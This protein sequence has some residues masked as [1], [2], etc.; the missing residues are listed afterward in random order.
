MS[1]HTLQYPKA[2]S[3]HFSEHPLTFFQSKENTYSVTNLL[4]KMLYRKICPLAQN[5]LYT[6]QL[7]IQSLRP[8][9][10][11]LI[12]KCSLVASEKVIHVL[13]IS[14]HCKACRFVHYAF[15]SH[16]MCDMQSM[17][18]TAPS[19]SLVGNLHRYN[20]SQIQS[21]SHIH[22]HHTTAALLVVL[23]C[24][25]CSVP[26]LAV[27]LLKCMDCRICFQPV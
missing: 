12:R 7:T 1:I 16:G 25:P 11:F 21:F 22:A 10:L 2:Q 18:L 17:G 23:A 26:E 8:Q 13:F 6:F 5:A 4:C 19:S 3:A 20:Y 15:S 24:S 27:P 14:E 9:T